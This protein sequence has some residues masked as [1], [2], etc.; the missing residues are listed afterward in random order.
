MTLFIETIQHERHVA[1]QTH[2]SIIVHKLI[3][4]YLIS[5]QTPYTFPTC[6]CSLALIPPTSIQL[7]PTTSPSL[8]TAT[9]LSLTHPL[10][11]STI[12]TPF[13]P[14]LTRPVIVLA[15][16]RPYHTSGTCTSIAPAVA[17]CSLRVA[18]NTSASAGVSAAGRS[19]FSRVGP[20]C[21]VVETFARNAASAAPA[22]VSRTRDSPRGKVDWMTGPEMVWTRVE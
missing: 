8:L 3:T 6:T 12:S 4:S 7:S 1:S 9:T 19:R 10:S 11:S 22:A 15:S 18:L 20:A 5:P 14:T 17:W 16:M 2:P 21:A 13:P